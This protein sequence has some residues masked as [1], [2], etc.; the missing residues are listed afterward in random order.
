MSDGT[1]VS[2]PLAR[3]G[4][5]V[6]EAI[7]RDPLAAA[8]MLT[9][10]DGVSH[11]YAE[12]RY[13]LAYANGYVQ[14]RDRLFEMDVLRH[15]G[16]GDSASVLGPGQLLS[17]V[18][19]RRDLYS[20][21]E[22][23]GQYEAASEETRTTLDAFA[24]GVN[25]QLVEM[26]TT[27]SL[28]AEFVALG[29]TPEPWSPVD[30]VAVSAYML[31]FFGVFGG[32]EFGN[33]E[34]FAE[35]CATGDDERAA[36]ERYGDLNWATA[37]DE[38]QP[39]VPPEEMTAADTP[40][41]AESVPAYADVP[42]AQLALARAA[43]EAE[44]W[45]MERDLGLL[46][47]RRGPVGRARS[48]GGILTGLKWGSNALAVHGDLTETGRPMLFGG[49][50]MGYFKPPI[51]HEIGLH[52]AGFD[53]VGVG[54]VG[55]PNVVLGRAPE[56]AWTMTSGYDDQVDTVAVELHPEDRHRYRT[57][58]DEAWR[59]MDTE[60]V[61]HRSSFVGSL[62][63][64]DS[65]TGVRVL[66]QEVARVEIDGDRC[67]VIAWHPDERVAWVQRATTRGDEL[68]GAF[69]WTALGRA[70]GYEEFVDTLADLP[71]S[72]NFLYADSEDIAYVHTGRLPERNPGL[73]PRFPA[74]AASHEWRDSHDGTDLGI[75]VRNPS[76]GYLAQWNN[77]PVAGWRA[78]D[79]EGRWGAFHRVDLLD[80]IVRE[81]LG[82][83]E[84]GHGGDRESGAE[85]E[86]DGDRPLSVDD[87]EGIV[88]DAATHDP[89]ARQTAPLLARV[90]AASDDKRLRWMAD[91]LDDWADAGY[92]W[93]DEQRIEV[94]DDPGHAV[95]DETRRAL[96]DLV[97][98]PHLGES[99]PELQLD[100]PTGI[101]PE[102]DEDPHAGDHG[103]TVREVALVGI[104]DGDADGDWLDDDVEAVVHRALVRA[105]DRLTERFGTSYPGSW[106]LPAHRSTFRVLG[107]A[108]EDAIPM[109][110]R[111]SYNFVVAL[112]P[113]GEPATT[114][115]SILPP[116]NSGHLPLSALV[117]TLRGT[118]PDRLTD[119][120]ARYEAFEYKP[121]P[122][123][124][125]AVEREA[126]RE[127]R[128]WLRPG[129]PGGFG[130]GLRDTLLGV[131][132]TLTTDL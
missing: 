25:R 128:L 116:S 48:P 104:L 4:R 14:A 69:E 121:M 30:S 78:G 22:L 63:D 122:V 103:R 10:T 7:D 23:R 125:D 5:R 97:F 17:D 46:S 114:A 71:F 75:V 88:R 34:R 1:R 19:V 102:G 8:E 79:E 61:V 72:F 66:E 31:G 36:F 106:R 96:Q 58:A 12:D 56:F 115:E 93:R 94:Y 105:A 13:T 42:E 2:G 62:A 74:P 65:G 29:H 113:A 51:V 33:A 95:W 123:E 64:P 67:P 60:R 129:R 20:K 24:N 57:S 28:P 109:V 81:R 108:N 110:N 84:D 89:T 6:A 111:G 83:A 127:K 126:T 16:Y 38:H 112:G 120:L 15:V 52:G 50:Q 77:A 99:T 70:D 118:D 49:P 132:L 117:S 47:D 11:V 35:L 92:P 68:D 85:A 44:P 40:V 130:S 37:A 131:G 59:T 100:P 26:A 87:I 76:R 55:T 18:Q 32:D 101:D 119:Q 45:G 82:R 107:A 98:R 41:S 91:E 54:V 73:D 53:V 21:A 124:R 86:P 80:R 9:D 27:G 3:V 90:A 43:G 39:T